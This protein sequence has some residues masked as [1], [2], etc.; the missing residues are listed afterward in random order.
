MV[1]LSVWPPFWYIHQHNNKKNDI[2]GSKVNR[3]EPQ[4]PVRESDEELDAMELFKVC[5]TNRKN[6]MSDDAREA[7][8]SP[9]AWFLSLPGFG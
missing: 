3:E 8:V 2:E 1:S 9:L 7:V 6:G 4:E 5:H